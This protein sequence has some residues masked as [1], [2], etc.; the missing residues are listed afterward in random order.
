MIGKF[1]VRASNK[2]KGHLGLVEVKEI[3]KTG[4]SWRPAVFVVDITT[5]CNFNCPHCLRQI[6]DKGKTRIQDLPTEVFETVL[7]EGKKSGFEFISFT[8]GEPILHPRFSDLV[9]LTAAYGYGFNL[10]SNGWFYKEYLPI[11]ERHR[12]RLEVLIFSLDGMSAEVHDKVRN[13]PGSF[14]KIM[15][16]VKF[17]RQ[18]DFPVMVNFAMNRQNHHQL[19]EMAEFCFKFG[20]TALKCINIVQPDQSDSPLSLN[21]EERKE[22]LKRIHDLSFKYGNQVNIFPT[23]SFFSVGVEKEISCPRTGA[24]NFCGILDGDHLL[25]DPDG[26]IL[27][28][29]DISPECKNKP[30][31]QELG[32]KKSLEITLDAAN[33]IKKRCLEALMNSREK[34][35]GCLK[36]NFCNQNIEEILTLV[37]SRL[38]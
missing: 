27:L 38:P 5:R 3:R 6:S 16:G 21:K 36:C 34:E 10:V 8:G 35:L 20:L 1:L 19:E 11:L 22:V 29:C 28:C 17:F 2:I 25:I 24:V 14:E 12:Q 23:S 26:G 9:D 4:S 15:E 37:R 13:K 33:E 32:F 30:L 7:K 18:L 31:I